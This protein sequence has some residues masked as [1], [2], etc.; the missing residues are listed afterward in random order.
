[1]QQIKNHH[2]KPDVT[3]IIKHASGL[4]DL[5]RRHCTQAESQAMLGIFLLPEIFQA[6][7]KSLEKEKGL[8]LRE[9]L[10]ACCPTRTRTLTDWT[11]TSCPA[12]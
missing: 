7:L 8:H 4:M 2:S 1:M 6:S 12:N 5:S 9:D 3:R 10:S 11:K